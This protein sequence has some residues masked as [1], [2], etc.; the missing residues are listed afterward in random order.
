MKN[1]FVKQGYRPSLINERL[2]RISELDRIDLVT[3][4]DA[5]HK[6]DRI[7]LVITYNQFLPNIIKNIKKNWNIV[8]INEN[9]K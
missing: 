4:K 2:K 1:N 8:Q 7:R 9:L 6:S 3:E 5:R